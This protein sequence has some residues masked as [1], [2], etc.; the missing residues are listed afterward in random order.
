LEK[1]LGLKD[2]AGRWKSSW[3][4]DRKSWAMEKQL[5]DWEIELGDGKVSEDEKNDER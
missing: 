2:K 4:I 3:A 1:E 5:G